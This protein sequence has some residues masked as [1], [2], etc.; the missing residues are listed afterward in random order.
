MSKKKLKKLSGKEVSSD[1][2]D[3]KVGAEILLLLY[4]NSNSYIQENVL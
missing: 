4:L 3:D 2:Q 1:G